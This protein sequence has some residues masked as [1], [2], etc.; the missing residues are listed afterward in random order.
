MAL[1]QP[2]GQAGP[3]VLTLGWLAAAV[4]G[5][6]LSGE[7]NM[8][9]G[10]VTTDTRTLERGDFFIALR[11]SRFD[12]HA[13]VGE[14][15]NHGAVGALVDGGFEERADVLTGGA[16][17]QV[18]DTT[19]ALQDL[20]HAVRRASGARVIA[21]TGSAGKTTTK[22]TIAALLGA[23]FR[24]V[25][26]RGNLNNH[27]G[28]PISLVELRER[29]DVAV[30]ELG[31]NHAG[32]ISTL[33]AVAEPDVRVWT[34]VGDAHLGFFASR[35]AIADAKAE[36]LERAD[37][38]SVLVCNADDPLVMA[39]TGSFLGRIVTFGTAD[40]ATVRA[41]AIED[42][43]VDGMRARV[44]TPIGEATIDTPL[45]GRGNLSNV[46][47][48]IAVAIDAGVPLEEIAAAAGRLRPA[49]HRGAVHR[50]QGG[51]TLI[52]DSYNSSPSAL[53]RALEV[54]A[55][56]TRAVG[57]VA[58]LGEMLELGESSTRL[59][60]ECGRAAARSGLRRL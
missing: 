49:D 22:E 44:T 31:M 37:P 30:M 25:K 48:A 23:R 24:V 12:G 52:D 51:V 39:R 53:A 11:G 60:E 21:I 6:V 4:G 43:G 59:H 34:N 9:I 47:A 19:T 56:E 50:L 5:R 17:V 40:G 10:H 42:R 46:L 28:L 15:I 32:E 2:S 55:R 13:F 57:K 36:I 20:G 58:V 26:N 29:P 38:S 8:P 27:I 7:A 45:L 1:R 41:T 18:A 35:E 16:I 33:V 14:A 54:V 3:L